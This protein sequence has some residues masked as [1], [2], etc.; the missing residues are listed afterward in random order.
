MTFIAGMAVGAATLS[1]FYDYLPDLVKMA[2]SAWSALGR[3]EETL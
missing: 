1:L 2:R 3:V